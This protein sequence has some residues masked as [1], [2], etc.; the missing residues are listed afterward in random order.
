MGC[1]KTLRF[2]RIA[3]RVTPPVSDYALPRLPERAPPTRLSALLFEAKV[4]ALRARHGLPATR[5]AL[6][7]KG[8]IDLFPYL[9]AWSRTRLWNDP[10]P[11]ERAAQQG[12]VQ[13]LRLA[14]AAFDRLVLTPGDA[15]SFWR[16]LGRASRRR[17]FVKG[18][19]LKEG[20]MVSA[21]GGGLCQLSNALH[22]VA[23]DGKLEIVERHGHSRIV[24]GSAAAV[25]CDATIAW[26]YVDLRFRAA[27]HTMLRVYLT[28]EELAV[29]LRGLSA[30]EAFILRGEDKGMDRTC[31]T[32]DQ[33][34]CFRHERDTGRE[35]HAVL[36]DEAWPEFR[37]LAA[38][39]D[40]LASPHAGTRYGWDRLRPA[41]T[42]PLA[43]LWRAFAQRRAKTAPER[44]AAEL[45][46]AKRIA[47]R[48]ARALTPDVTEVTVA[49]S[50]LPT[51]W[52]EGH[53]GGRRFRVLMT[54]MPMAEIQARLDAAAKT[55]PGRA[56]LADFRADPALLAAETEALA[57]ADKI[58]TPHAE[59]A[60]LF[61]E[62]AVLVDWRMPKPLARKGA[63]VPDRI[64]FPGPTIARKGAYELREAARALD[65][66]VVLI[67]SELEGSGFWNGVRTIRAGTTNWLDGVACV[68]QPALLE[69]APRR[70]FEAR[71]SGVPVIA[72]AACGL[73]GI[74]IIPAD[75]VAALIAAIS[76]EL[77]RPP[78]PASRTA[79]DRV[80]PAL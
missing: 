66:E 22:A 62:R 4:W 44:R 10:Q 79:P 80:S 38:V 42:A 15:F 54:R 26:N 74:T 55:H 43:A 59:I 11:A 16:Q 50:L 41:A 51:L 21:V 60:R 39:G 29:E 27:Q 49:Q 31:A 46:G 68:V 25:G 17:G 53:L 78:H 23:L 75:D 19:M 65:L 14:A 13:N 64:V 24:P 69:D 56:S 70:L 63:V 40:V 35:R 58:V 72:T 33:T 3:S 1:E 47:R 8:D 67:G 77:G 28:A 6:L 12:K 45:R 76:S 20:C 5:P 61:G 73:D 2:A 18:R 57:A 71:A 52:R 7:T 32:C 36:T 9:I 34:G 48:L 37:A 30:G